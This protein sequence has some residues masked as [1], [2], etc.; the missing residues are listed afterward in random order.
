MDDLSDM[1][2]VI[3]QYERFL[4]RT[5]GYQHRAP[6]G[7]TFSLDEWYQEAVVAL[8]H[9]RNTFRPDKGSQFVTWAHICVRR[10]LNRIRNTSCTLIRVPS[11][12]LGKTKPDGE[13]ARRKMMSL[14]IGDLDVIE[15]GREDTS[16]EDREYVLSL[17]ARLSPA[18]A[19]ILRRHFGID[20]EAESDSEMA[21]A[22]GIHRVTIGTRRRRA[23]E[24]LRKLLE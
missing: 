13:R 12:Q 23:M 10:A 2:A 19:E 22:D 4:W 8:I 21:Q 16:D 5:A 18:D 7:F 11:Y 6:L 1:D 24:R 3:R 17:L 14:N 9:A 15:T 20:R